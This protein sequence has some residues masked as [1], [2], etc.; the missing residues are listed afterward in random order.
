MTPTS[1]M[2]LDAGVD[3]KAWDNDGYPAFFLAADHGRGTETIQHHL[4]AGMDPDMRNEKGLTALHIAAAGGS[5][6]F[7]RHAGPMSM[8]NKKMVSLQSIWP[9]DAAI[10]RL[11]NTFWDT[12]WIW[13]STVRSAELH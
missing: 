3:P 5:S 13:K 12:R 1:K 9:R 8:Q 6:S 7:W 11:S 4:D 2:L 10:R